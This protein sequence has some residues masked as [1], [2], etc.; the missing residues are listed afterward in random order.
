LILNPG[1][2]NVPEALKPFSNS[3]ELWKFVIQLTF[4]FQGKNIHTSQREVLLS[5]RDT[6]RNTVAAAKAKDLG[7]GG[8]NV[9]SLNKSNELRY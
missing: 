9:I 8:V 1:E 6:F 5:A 2:E 3:W 7:A 4:M